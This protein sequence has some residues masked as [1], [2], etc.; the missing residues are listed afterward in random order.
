M[1]EAVTSG[2]ARKADRPSDPMVRPAGGSAT[3]GS[4]ATREAVIKATVTGRA[5]PL[6]GFTAIDVDLFE[7]VAPALARQCR[8]DGHIGPA[9]V[10]SVAQHCVLMAQAAMHETRDHRLAAY[11]LLH[12]AH[13]AYIGDITTPTARWFAALEREHFH[14]SGVVA[15]IIAIAKKKLDAAIWAAAELPPPGP[16]HAAQ[17]KAFDVR[18]LATERRQLLA[19]SRI[20]LGIEVDAALPIRTVGSIRPWPV[21]KAEEAYRSALQDY[22]QD[23]R[24]R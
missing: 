5:F 10:Y 20:D 11:C 8:F 12:D 15:G 23:A 24:R 16:H 9:G 18:M 22:C 2:A 21:G 4:G 14:S 17:V 7:D 6:T 13:E 19:P 1:T 3:A